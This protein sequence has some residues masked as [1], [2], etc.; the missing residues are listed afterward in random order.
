MVCWFAFVVKILFLG[1][2]TALS[3]VM[4]GREGLR[5]FLKA[6]FGPSMAGCWLLCRECSRESKVLLESNLIDNLGLC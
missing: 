3:W 1:I 6:Y 2:R 5:L 4:T